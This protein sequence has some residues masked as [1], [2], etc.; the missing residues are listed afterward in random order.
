[1]DVNSE[2]VKRTRVIRGY[3]ND[4]T[5]S[6]A[7]RFGIYEIDGAHLHNPSVYGA[8][9]LALSYGPGHG[10][11]Q[12]SVSSPCGTLMSYLNTFE[13]HPLVWFPLR[14]ACSFNVYSSAFIC[15][16]RLCFPCP[17]KQTMGHIVGGRWSCAVLRMGV[18]CIGGSTASPQSFRWVQPNW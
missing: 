8:G 11:A 5:K 9:E 17:E 13:G 4:M 3:R 12:G 16:R 2:A 15:C 14:S 6:G 1:M 7:S 18:S 10:F